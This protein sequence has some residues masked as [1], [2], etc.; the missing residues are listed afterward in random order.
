M[1][2]PSATDRA[3]RDRYGA[4]AKERESALCCAV[5]YDPRHLEAIPQEVIDRD[6]GCGDPSR[7]I[8]K[9]ETV[10][11]LGS[12]GGKICFIASQLVGPEG[13][14]LGVDTNDEMLALAR[15][16]TTEVA[17]RV[18][19]ANVTFLRGQIEDLALDHDKLDTWLARHP[20]QSAS[21]LPRF[22]EEKDRLRRGEPMVKDHSVDIVVSNCVLNLVHQALKPQLIEG[23]FRVV[24]PGGRIAISDI[25]SDRIV[26]DELRADPELWS[27]CVSGA[28]HEPEL[29]RQLERVG[30][31]SIE[32]DRAEGDPFAVVEGIE[33]RSVTFTAVKPG[34]ETS[35]GCC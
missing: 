3:V 25:V 16:S 21:D 18:G 11:D 1:T 26:P 34:N 19:H 7:F 23:I 4:A 24:K 15:R 33:F 28:F 13:A 35:S 29:I 31:R 10:L 2:K 17:E 20:I 22:E 12:G 14:V 6:Y 9:G 27:G 8:R 30:F 5:S 32:L